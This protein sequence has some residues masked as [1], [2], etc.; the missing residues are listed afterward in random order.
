MKIAQILNSSLVIALAIAI[1]AWTLLAN[2]ADGAETSDLW[3]FDGAIAFDEQIKPS[4]LVTVVRN[5]RDSLTLTPGADAVLQW[6]EENEHVDVLL[7]SGGV[8]FSTQA[9]DFSVS[10]HTDTVRVDSQESMAYVKRTE[11]GSVEVYG[12]SHPSLLTFTQNGLA[13]NALF[14]PNGMMI[15]V[16]ESKVTQ[17]LERIRL[18]KLSKEFRSEEWESD[19]FDEAVL[20]A[21]SEAKFR[22]TEQSV[23]YSQEVQSDL[24][25]GPSQSGLGATLNGFYENFKD[26][27]TVLPTAKERLAETRKENILVYAMSNLL[28]GEVTKGDQWVD[29]WAAKD[30]S[31]EEIESI[32]SDLFFVLPGDELY[33]VKTAA[34]SLAFDQE[35]SLASM[36]RQ[37]LEIES[38]LARGESADA[39]SALR[40]YQKTV[41]EALDSGVLDDPDNLNALSREYLLVELLL[42]EN[43]DFYNVEYASLLMDMEEKI[44]TLA[45]DDT[46]LDEERQAF[47][48]SKIQFLNELF[49]FVVDRRVSVEEASDLANELLFTAED[50]LALISSDV[51][52]RDWYEDELERADLAIAFIN[53]PEFYSYADFET[54]LAAYAAKE[55]DLED[56]QNYIQEIREGNGLELEVGITLDEA[57]AEVR[58]AFTFEAISYLT[59]ESQGDSGYRLFSIVSG[60]VDEYEFEASYDREGMLLYDLVIADQIRFSTGVLLSDLRNVIEQALSETPLLEDSEEDLVAGEESLTDGLAIVQAEEAFEAEG[61]EVEDFTIEV[62]DRDAGLFSFEGL[63]TGYD[64]PIRGEFSLE[65]A[66][67]METTWDLG[68]ETHSLPD[69]ALSQLEGAVSAVYKALSAK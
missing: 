60:K 43:S 58:Q 10:V 65:S 46:D 30:H 33:S 15:G 4:E 2:P 69:M 34:I 8:L 54:G 37:F 45:G 7:S 50:Y 19:D 5:E 38:L 55:Q 23:A 9:N 48:L 40:D 13:L 26:F 61:F 17:T 28:F 63:I 11:D 12:L 59:A 62:L 21:W 1:G 24:N 20:S 51:A 32:Y 64:L 35:A 16:P 53:S 66:M 6:D 18:T 44:L 49:D 42:R 56:L 14:V 52:V 27:A 25:F 29:E 47:V 36:R 3:I 67:V 68:P 57:L 22:Y 41:K 31:L 39:Q